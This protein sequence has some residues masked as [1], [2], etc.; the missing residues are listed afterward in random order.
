MRAHGSRSAGP[1][2]GAPRWSA[3]ADGARTL[4]L[5][6]RAVGVADRSLT[7]DVAGPVHEVVARELAVMAAG[8]VLVLGGA[9]A[10]GRLSRRSL[11]MGRGGEEHAIAAL[12][13]RGAELAG[14]RPAAHEEELGKIGPSA[15]ALVDS[16]RQ[17]SH[18]QALW[19]LHSVDRWLGPVAGRTGT[20]VAASQP[21]ADEGTTAAAAAMVGRWWPASTGA[22]LAGGDVDVVALLRGVSPTLAVL[23]PAPWAEVASAVRST[24]DRTSAGSLLLRQGRVAASHGP[25]SRVERGALAAARRRAGPRLRTGMGVG[26]LVVGVGLG[27]VDLQTDRDL[28]AAGV[29]IA[30]TWMVAGAAAPV[31]SEPL[32]RR[33]GADVWMRPLPGRAVRSAPGRTW[34]E[35]GDLPADGL[36]QAGMAR[37]GLGDRVQPPRLPSRRPNGG[38]R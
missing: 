33:D 2:P 29:P 10:D 3:V 25:S 7:V 38:S 14:A 23:G 32:A 9:P 22:A 35:G 37:I 20:V 13:V 26:E 36:E 5:G 30:S 19:A 6:L 24:A 18:G 12:R 21:P 16:E 27:R 17:I 15:A 11:V 34:V 4:A 1:G 28:A 31:A 8:A